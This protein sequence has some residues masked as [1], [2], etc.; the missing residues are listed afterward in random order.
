MD[1][2]KVTAISVSI[3]A[4]GV[5]VGG[6]NWGVKEF[7]KYKKGSARRECMGYGSKYKTYM[8]IATS[9]AYSQPLIS[10]KALDEA[11]KELNKCLAEKGYSLSY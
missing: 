8:D 7:D 11:Q 4:I 5:V 3:L 2:N 9:R 10:S 6:I 1:T